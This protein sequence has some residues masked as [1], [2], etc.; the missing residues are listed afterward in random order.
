MTGVSPGEMAKSLVDAGADVVGT[1]CGNGMAG[2]ADIVRAI[3]SVNRDIPVLVHANAGKPKIEN[4][5]TV[6]PETPWVM[7][8]LTPG[9]IR[10]GASIV[11]G[12][13]G[14]TP[15]HIRAIADAVQAGIMKRP[16]SAA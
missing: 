2:M 1:N 9:L 7:A 6:F 13:C 5:K 4:G 8:G 14:T 10:A 15:A 12:C 16:S 11:G 3:R